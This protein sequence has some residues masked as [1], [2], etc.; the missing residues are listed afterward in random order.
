MSAIITARESDLFSRWEDNFGKKEGRGICAELRYKMGVSL[1]DLEAI[2]VACKERPPHIP[3]RAWAFGCRK[4]LPD[5]NEDGTR[6]WRAE[7]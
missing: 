4:N 7:R 2:L 5:R 1:D 3:L 6:R